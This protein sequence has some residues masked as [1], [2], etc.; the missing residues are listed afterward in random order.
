MF[1]VDSEQTWSPVHSSV[2]ICMYVC[3][4]GPGYLGRYSFSLWVGRS[5]DRIPV[6]TKFSTPVQTGLGTHPASYT[7]GTGSFPGVKRPGCGV[8]HPTPSST[9]VK[10]RVELYFYSPSGP[11]WPVLG[12]S[13]PLPLYMYASNWSGF[14]HCP[15]CTGDSQCMIVRNAYISML[16]NY[17]TEE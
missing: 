15:A 9:E 4:C 16:K 14:L 11:S 6:R 3:I 10:K 5:G 17:I 12:W 2:G 7:T 1:W 13:L 8:D